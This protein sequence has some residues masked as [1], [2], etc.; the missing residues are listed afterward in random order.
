MQLALREYPELKPQVAPSMVRTPPLQRRRL[1]N[2]REFVG[3]RVSHWRCKVR[4]SG[5]IA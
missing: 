2:Q 3:E 1:R 5:E 4:R